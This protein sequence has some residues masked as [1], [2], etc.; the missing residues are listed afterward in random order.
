GSLSSQYIKRL[1]IKIITALRYYVQFQLDTRSQ[2]LTVAKTLGFPDKGIIGVAGY[3]L[4]TK[5]LIDLL[6]SVTSFPICEE[7]DEDKCVPR[8]DNVAW[9]CVLVDEGGWVVAR[10]KPEEEQRSE[11]ED[12]VTEH[13]ATLYPTAM[14]ALLN[15]SVFELNW[16]HDYQGVC[17]PPKDEKSNFSPTMPSIL[18][19]L[20]HSAQSILRITQELATFLL[21]LNSAMSVSAE[22]EKEKQKRRNRLW[23]DNE[24]EKY[25]SLYDDRVLINRTRFAACDRSR[26]F[27][28]MQRTPKAMEMLKTS[29][30]LQMAAGRCHSTED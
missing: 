27:Y 25:E 22:T 9:A 28:Q 12:D 3:H 7:E 21:V 23:R 15:A 8:C 5:H 13:L 11:D 14:G 24:R 19:S 20:W 30:A 4:H 2:W 18:R 29:E 10:D 6:S 1:D 26:P 16:I 17:F